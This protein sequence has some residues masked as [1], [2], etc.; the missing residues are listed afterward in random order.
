MLLSLL[1]PEL[2]QSLAECM[3]AAGGAV[4]KCLSFDTR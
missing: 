3:Y 4:W 2:S 1:S